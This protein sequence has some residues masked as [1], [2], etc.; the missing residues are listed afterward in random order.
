MFSD[1]VFLAAFLIG[2]I[3]GLRSL[4]APA[5][6]AWS[7]QFHWIS[8]RGTLLAFLGSWPAVGVF[9]FFAI[10]EYLADKLP[11]T[12][13]RT[14]P[15]GLA[16]RIIF[17]ALSGAALTAAKSVNPG[18][19]AILGALGGIVGAFAGCHIRVRAV[20]AFPA[21]SFY[22]AVLE[23]MVAILGAL[24]IIELLRPV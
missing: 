22:F 2:I 10:T 20:R 8:L 15:L 11:R 14:A 21:R 17:G 18:L 4:T 12:P 23:D 13:P 5:V 19:G 6:V 7:V 24:A 3:S 9:T 1:Y 16:A